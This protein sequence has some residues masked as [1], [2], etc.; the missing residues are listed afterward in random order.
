MF[1]RLAFFIVG[2]GIGIFAS[3]S[4]RGAAKSVIGVAYKA[5][6]ALSGL[7]AEAVEDLQDEK[8]AEDAARPR[9]E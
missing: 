8:A 9:T 6:S 5:R 7:A 3:G 4:L 2:A 1:S